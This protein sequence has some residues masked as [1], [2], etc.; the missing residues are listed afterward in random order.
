MTNYPVKIPVFN[1]V[2]K[3]R[4]MSA[5]E[6]L[7]SDKPLLVVIDMV[8]SKRTSAQNRLY[9]GLWLREVS[10]RTGY[11]VDEVHEFCKRKFM[12]RIYLAEPMTKV[13]GKWVDA[14]GTVVELCEGLD[15]DAAIEAKTQVLDLISTTWA[16]VE[17]FTEYL[18]RVEQ[19]YQAAGI[20]LP[21][22][23]DVYYEAMGY[24]RVS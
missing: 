21:H 4:A 15:Q 9:W 6:H 19:Y 23:D 8:K 24:E 14:W 5:I 3:A 13:Q 12:S 7:P 17:Q 18:N 22:P 10:V 2:D 11:S 20:P 16:K 1:A